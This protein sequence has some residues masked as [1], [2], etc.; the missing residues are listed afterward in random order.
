MN[1]ARWAIAVM[2]FAALAAN[3]QTISQPASAW[4]TASAAAS[5]LSDA[6]LQA[7]DAAVRSGDFKKIGSVL[8]A[9]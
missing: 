2:L 6:R 3:S 9:R 5:G 7:L 4:P 8:I 1:A